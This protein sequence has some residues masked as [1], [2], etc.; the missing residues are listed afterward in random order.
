[1]TSSK[2]NHEPVVGLDGLKVARAVV[3]ESAVPHTPLVAIGGITA[4]NAAKVIAHADAI[5]VIGALVGNDV[6]DR[7]RA[8]Q[9]A[10]GFKS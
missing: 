9:K 10:I 2:K 5:A 8:L 6:G 3:R 4:E 7:F 1:A